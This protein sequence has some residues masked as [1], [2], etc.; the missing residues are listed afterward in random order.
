MIKNQREILKL[1]NTILQLKKKK[2]KL[3]NVLNSQMDMT[4]ERICELED[5]PIKIFQTDS[6]Y[7]GGKNWKTKM[8]KALGTC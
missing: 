7:R 5:K 3:L 4:E 8:I 2:Q 1:R 6:E